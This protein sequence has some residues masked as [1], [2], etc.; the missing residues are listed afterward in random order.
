VATVVKPVIGQLLHSLCMGGAEVLAARIARQLSERYDF[1]FACLDGLESLG[2]ELRR[3]GFSVEVIGRKPGF[4]FGCV[5]RLSRWLR[6]QRIEVLHAHQYT[7]FFYGAAARYLARGTPVLFTEHGRFFP[8]LPSRKRSLANRMLLRKRDRV[9]G[10]GEA[11]RQALIH[12]EGIP[13]VRVGVVYNGIDLDRFAAVSGERERVRTELGIGADDFVLLQVAR[14]DHLKDH[15]TAL[16][17]VALVAKQ[18]P[19]VR[20]IL[21]GEGPERGKIEA[22]VAEQRLGEQVRLLGLRTD[23]PR[24]LTAADAA[25]LTS[26]S[27]GI[28]LTLIE[29][30]AARLPVVSTNVGGVSE[31]V[32]DGVT[33]FLAPSGDAE[34]LSRWV[35][36]LIAEPAL[37]HELGERG[38]TRAETHFSE[39]QMLAAYAGLYE[40]MH[41][42]G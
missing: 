39:R 30:M 42:R 38:R 12:N 33:G 28:P 25:L 18:S 32:K 37:R 7:P 34:G 26:I 10:V 8:D 35:L 20:L 15:L 24:L 3:D 36:R 2:E 16:R 9:V 21:V 22:F 1:H 40:E 4:D 23:V 5:W 11:V 14:L 31:V 6:R 29:A 41:R 19:R 13:A 27:E 17:T